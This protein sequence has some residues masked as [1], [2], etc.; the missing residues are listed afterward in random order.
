MSRDAEPSAHILLLLETGTIRVPLR[1][2]TISLGTAA[3]AAVGVL[4]AGVDPQHA[5]IQQDGERFEIFD[6]QSGS[7]TRVNGERVEAALLRHG[8]LIEVGPVRLVFMSGG[9][10]P[11]L[12]MPAATLE[13]APPP[14]P[15][16]GAL[17]ARLAGLASSGARGPAGP[18]PLEAGPDPAPQ[19][20]RAEWPSEPFGAVL[21]AALRRTPPVLI[22][23]AVHGALA[24]LLSLFTMPER[25]PGRVAPVEARVETAPAVVEAPDWVTAPAPDVE[26]DPL[27]VETDVEAEESPHSPQVEEPTGTEGD[28][29]PGEAPGP[30]RSDP[31]LGPGRLGGGGLPAGGL[32]TALRRRASSLDALRS[33]GLDLVFVIDSTGSMGR[34]LAL[35]AAE[36]GRMIVLLDA[37]V[38]SFRLGMV[39][40]RDHG[41]EY[42]VR[43][44]RLRPDAYRIV[45]F[46]DGIRAEGGGDLP[47]AVDAG[48]E[49]AIRGS[50]WS[51]RAR[52]I[53]ILV[54]D[55][56]PHPRG[57]QVAL[58]L[59]RDFGRSGGV[60]HTLVVPTQGF[61]VRGPEKE[62]AAQFA[63]IAAAAG[64]TSRPLEG[65]AELTRIVV[66]AA[67]RLEDE[68][69]ADELIRAADQDFR[70]RQWS[71]RLL[72]ADHE[73]LRR[74]LS[75]R[76]PPPALLR[77]IADRP[78]PALL[79]LFLAL[80]ADPGA[81]ARARSACL[82]AL[83]RTV[84][85]A[86]PESEAA[87]ALYRENAESLLAHPERLR[88]L[89]AAA[90]FATSFPALVAPR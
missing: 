8:D 74:H 36:I 29:A 43:E 19:A 22:S 78:W 65:G 77:E 66:A 23:A 28:Q 85:A 76:E 32:G 42:L 24:L 79:P 67:L 80:A 81:P 69:E 89:L 6:L 90:G 52:R 45:H 64:G 84:R 73:T 25:P 7:G 34:A 12:Q 41:D 1:G 13:L 46:L 15:A 4:G 54:G 20:H 72:A 58:D 9:P 83:A 50:A 3:D 61:G 48:L 55:A 47:E 37:I 26:A 38:P 5:V 40:Y 57:I 27:P 44:E 51:P 10:A 35:A 53:V 63:R 30:F 14:D 87:A 75:R 2:P 68:R 33:S 16:Q 49:R 59:A 11:A 56:P 86:A 31:A 60:I 82:V 17:R 70:R 71:A 39:T 62:T 18:G 21:L 88:R